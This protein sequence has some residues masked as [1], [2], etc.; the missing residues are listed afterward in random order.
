MKIKLTES[1]KNRI[2]KL[3]DNVKEGAITETLSTKENK[4]IQWCTIEEVT[5]NLDNL[6]FIPGNCILWATDLQD[7]T[8]MQ[9]CT[10]SAQKR[11][12]SGKWDEEHIEKLMEVI[13]DRA[14]GLKNCLKKK[15]IDVTSMI[16]DELGDITL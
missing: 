11:V 1:E 13:V 5:S 14:L 10:A 7:M 2:L 16:A 9:A 15:G 8:K 6:K 4:A 3:H 12:D